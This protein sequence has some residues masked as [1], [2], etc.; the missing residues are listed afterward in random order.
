MRIFLSKVFVLFLLAGLAG[1]GFHLRGAVEVPEQLRTLGV[2]GAAPHGDLGMALRNALREN[3]I[4]VLMGEDKRGATQLQVLNYRVERRVLSISAT[5]GRAREYELFS[6]LTFRVV[7]GRGLP[8]IGE[9]TLTQLR[10]YSFDENEV[11]ARSAEES[12]LRLEMRRD[13]IQAVLRRLQS[14]GRVSERSNRHSPAQP[15]TR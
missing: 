11:L 9:A 6:S 3:G 7:D 10:D 15:S 12:Q 4:H 14:A 2:S 13:L 5:S 1:C 8:I